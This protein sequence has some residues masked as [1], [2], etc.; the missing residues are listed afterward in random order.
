MSLLSFGLQPPKPSLPTYTLLP[1]DVGI[2][3]PVSSALPKN[4]PSGAKVEVPVE[5]VPNAARE[6]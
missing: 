6:P 1:L 3:H 2:Q 5:G 4:Q